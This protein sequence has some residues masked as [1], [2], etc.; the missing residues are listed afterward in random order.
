MARRYQKG[1][2]FLRGKNQD[3]W[4]GRFREDVRLP[5][6]R[7]KRVNRNVRLGTIEELST[8]RLARRELDKH[9]EAINDL[10]YRPS[11]R[12]TFTQFIKMWEKDYLPTLKP[13][14]QDTE[15]SYVRNHILP[16]FGECL[17]SEVTPQLVQRFVATTRVAPSSLIGIYGTLR[18]I[19]N[20]AALWGKVKHNPFPRKGIKLPPVDPTEREPFTVEETQRIIRAANEPYRTLY[21][22]IAETGIRIGEAT[23]LQVE[24]IDFTAGVLRVRK[25]MNRH[26]QF[27]TPKSRKGKRNPALSPE[28]L[29]HLHTRYA[30]ACG[31]LFPS[32]KGAISYGAAHDALTRVL[33]RLGINRRGF[34][35]FRYG[36]GTLLVALGRDA[37]AEPSWAWQG[38]TVGRAVSATNYVRR[39]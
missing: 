14:S 17:L 31:F 4:Y 2:L 6:G 39:A 8:K 20:T 23:A 25:N 29:T 5:D 38:G 36:N 7:V 35:C 26:R 15:K 21:W 32:P 37:A 3:V 11:S 19:W 24:D 33:D 13:N 18:G 34:H 10:D 1:Q 12:L 9:L 28:L 22:L 27:G 30:G 16:F